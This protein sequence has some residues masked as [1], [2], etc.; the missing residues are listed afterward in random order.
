MASSLLGAKRSSPSGGAGLNYLTSPE[1]CPYASWSKSAIFAFYIIYWN[2]PFDEGKLK[3]LTF[4]LSPR[5]ALMA[6]IG[7]FEGQ[8]PQTEEK[9]Q[10]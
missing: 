2:V 5:M 7:L 6:F 3:F 1:Q 8:I 10:S 9:N 4:N